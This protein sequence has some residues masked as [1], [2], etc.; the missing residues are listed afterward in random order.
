MAPPT[1][2]VPQGM[3]MG[4]Y[5]MPPAGY[6]P[7]HAPYT[8]MGFP[9][10]MIPI[11]DQRSM[12]GWAVTSNGGPLSM[13]QMPM[14]AYPQQG[15]HA[16]PIMPSISGYGFNNPRISNQNTR[17]VNNNGNSRGNRH[18]GGNRHNGQYNSNNYGPAFNH[19]QHF[20]GNSSFGPVNSFGPNIGE[21]HAP[22]SSLLSESYDSTAAPVLSIPT[23]L[24][25]AYVEDRTTQLQGGTQ[26]PPIENGSG[27]EVPSSQHLPE[28]SSVNRDSAQRRP[29]NDAGMKSSIDESGHAG[30]MRDHPGSAG[31]VFHP[32]AGKMEPRT[33]MKPNGS[34][35]TKENT[36]SNNKSAKDQ[37][38]RQR[39]NHSNGLASSGNNSGASGGRKQRNPSNSGIRS[40]QKLVS[41]ANFNMDLDFPT[42]VNNFSPTSWVLISNQIFNQKTDAVSEVP[43]T[44]VVVTK[45]AVSQG[46]RDKFGSCTVYCDIC[47]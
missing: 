26:Q 7:M 11:P 10:A 20:M 41:T 34:P 2:M 46:R 22:S 12:M 14:M 8:V 6:Y 33:E 5:Q 38:E 15:M 31:T 36:N 29:P 39:D 16:V 25:N 40:G 9:P 24:S 35:R 23:G 43:P 17:H 28:S 32:G 4:G 18:T 21:S 47:V 44:L 42:L 13:S 19:R 3:Y 30:A 27:V 1:M 37:K 45:A